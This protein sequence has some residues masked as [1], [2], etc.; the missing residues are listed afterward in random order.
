MGDG[1][2]ADDALLIQEEGDDDNGD[3]EENL[4]TKPPNHTGSFAWPE[5]L[6]AISPQY[7]P[8]TSRLERICMGMGITKLSFC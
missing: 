4:A 6:T 8:K 7:G 5:Q 3:I 1:E 2:D